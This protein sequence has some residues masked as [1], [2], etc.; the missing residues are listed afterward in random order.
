MVQVESVLRYGGR[1]AAFECTE[2]SGGI[3]TQVSGAVESVGNSGSWEY[4]QDG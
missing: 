1:H 4:S 2:D 3:L